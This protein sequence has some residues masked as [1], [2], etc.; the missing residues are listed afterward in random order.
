MTHLV[1][2]YLE[3]K[4]VLFHLDRFLLRSG[5]ILEILILNSYSFMVKNIYIQVSYEIMKLA[6]T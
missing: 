3:Q 2:A 1:V 5:P 4:P 6:S